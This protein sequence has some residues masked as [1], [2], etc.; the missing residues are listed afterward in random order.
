MK[1]YEEYEILTVESDI[2]KHRPH[3]FYLCGNIGNQGYIIASYSVKTDR[4]YLKDVSNFMPTQQHLI[5]FIS[6][7]KKRYEEAK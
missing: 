5:D 3:I 4:L 2:I 7:A 6:I 1:R